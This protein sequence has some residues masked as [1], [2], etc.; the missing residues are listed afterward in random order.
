[1]IAGQVRQSRHEVPDALVDAGSADADEHVVLACHR[2]VDVAEFQCFGRAI[3]VLDDRLHGGGSPSWLSCSWRAGYAVGR[4]PVITKLGKP[5]RE[6]IAAGFRGA[7]AAAQSE[8]KDTKF[9]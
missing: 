6:S 2:L 9:P 8:I 1:M 7:G 5:G 4:K 3:H